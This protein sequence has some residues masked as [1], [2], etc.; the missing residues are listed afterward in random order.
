MKIN[1]ND[2]VFKCK[3]C[4]TTDS[5]TSGMMNQ[6]FNHNFNGMVFMMPKKTEQEFWMYNCLIPLD[7]IMIDGDT[8]TKINRNC[9]PC[10]DKTNC[11]Y[12]SGYGDRVL[13][14]DGGVCDELGIKEGDKVRTSLY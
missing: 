13:E 14:I 11:D 5:I 2:N 1:I 3:V 4:N 12:Y 7:I 6:T 8:I 10:D 9:Q